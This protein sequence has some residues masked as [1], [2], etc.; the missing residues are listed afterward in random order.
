[1]AETQLLHGRGPAPAA[2]RAHPGARA[3]RETDPADPADGP[4]FRQALAHWP[5]LAE[6]DR[7]LARSRRAPSARDD[8]PD[9]AR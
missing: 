2:L 7:Y 6:M 4:S 8:D 9:A 3:R 5:L 1:M